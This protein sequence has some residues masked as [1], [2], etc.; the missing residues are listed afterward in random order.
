MHVFVILVSSGRFLIA[1]RCI[2]GSSLWLD[3]SR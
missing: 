2:V 3:A 1:I